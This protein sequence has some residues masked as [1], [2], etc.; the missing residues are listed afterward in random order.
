MCS[1][2]VGRRVGKARAYFER[3]RVCFVRRPGRA[4]EDFVARKR[5]REGTNRR[6][7]YRCVINFLGVCVAVHSILGLC[8][9]MKVDAVQ[10]ERW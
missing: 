8:V 5:N 9:C 10:C 4:T 3:N 2:R 6:H 1:E 7:E